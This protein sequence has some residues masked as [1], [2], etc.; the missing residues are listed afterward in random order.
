[1]SFIAF[2]VGA[3]ET[4]LVVFFFIAVGIVLRAA[5]SVAAVLVLVVLLVT[6]LFAVFHLF[7][8]LFFYSFTPS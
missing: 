8:S 3:K 2:S 7:F 6:V 4:L 5:I 1:M